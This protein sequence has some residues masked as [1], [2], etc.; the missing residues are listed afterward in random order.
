MWFHR[1][2]A[3]LEFSSI[4]DKTQRIYEE[5]EFDMKQRRVSARQVHRS[6]VPSENL[7]VM[8]S[9]SFLI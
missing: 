5:L 1:N 6:N 8:G 2:D 4:F 9:I 3:S 7:E